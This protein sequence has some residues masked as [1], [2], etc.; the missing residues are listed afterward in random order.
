MIAFLSGQ[1]YN[2]TKHGNE[3]SAHYIIY[4]AHYSD[5]DAILIFS[6]PPREPVLMS[7]SA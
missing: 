6:M 5:L 3:S 2:Y 4:E 7:A 1:A